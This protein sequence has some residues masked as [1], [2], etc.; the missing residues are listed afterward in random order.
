MLTI[1]LFVLFGVL[2][3]AIVG[4]LPGLHPNTIAAIV[5]YGDYGIEISVFLFSCLISSNIFE[6][7]SAC[8]LGVPEEGEA[9]AKLPLQN[10][11]LNK[12][13]LVAMKIVAFTSIITYALFLGIG[14][15]LQEIITFVYFAVKDFAWIILVAICTHLIIKEKNISLALL[16]FS[17]SGILG[18]ITFNIE[19]N[20]PFLPLLTGLFGLSGLVFSQD[21]KE[22]IPTQMKQVVVES[23]FF[24]LLKAS[25][26]GI[27]GS[28]IMA[29]VPSMSPSQVGL[30]TEEFKN[31]RKNDEL[32]IASMTSINI[33]DNV[34]SLIALV[35]IGKGR[36][37]V[38]EKIGE[39]ITIDNSNYYILLFCGFLAC[40]IGS[41]FLIKTSIF[42][43]KKTE[44]F[45]NKYV[46]YGVITFVTILTFLFNGFAGLI[47]LSLS[48]ILGYFC[49]KNNVR[50]SQLLGCLVIPTILFYIRIL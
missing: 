8:Y 4:I 33:S 49:V 15:F 26:I 12:R 23:S 1:L 36:S 16:F 7:L 6:F 34:L 42:V 31:G 35:S 14:M 13:S 50:R 19:L 37:G 48:T 10:L 30:I 24:E 45:N 47:I 38:V 25:A 43:S 27:I 39:L 20:E 18:L 21:K 44:W 11:L 22:T 32:K 5:I 28:I 41:Y 29:I 17:L 9:L 40:V 3:G 46:T 2:V